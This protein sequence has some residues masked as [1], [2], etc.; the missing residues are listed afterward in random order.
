MLR[1]KKIPMRMC[2][3][4]R[5]KRPKQELLRVVH[6]PDGTITVDLTGKKPGRGAYICRDVECL[7]R[8][9]RQ[10]QLE[11]AFSCAISP[12]TYDALEATVISLTED[13]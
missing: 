3:S 1:T 4:C 2:V 12:E 7:K 6:C 8:S 10:R 13:A 5:E 11:R 9:R